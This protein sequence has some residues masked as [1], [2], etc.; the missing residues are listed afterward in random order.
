MLYNGYSVQHTD[1]PELPLPLILQEAVILYLF[2]TLHYRE[3]L[4]VK[5]TYTIAPVMNSVHI[6]PIM[7]SS[8]RSTF[9]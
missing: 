4:P 7:S 6:L 1:S 5:T 2:Y 8:S 9:C 3:I